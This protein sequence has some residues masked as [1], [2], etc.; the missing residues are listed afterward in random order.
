MRESLGVNGDWIDVLV[1]EQ[2]NADTFTDQEEHSLFPPETLG[3]DYSEEFDPPVRIGT[4]A[5]QEDEDQVDDP[6]LE[7]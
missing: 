5:I 7:D 4:N 1:E 3:R 2:N 6:P